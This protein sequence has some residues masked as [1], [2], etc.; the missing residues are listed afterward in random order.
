M[1][2]SLVA[3]LRNALTIMSPLLGDDAPEEALLM[4]SPWMLDA[5]RVDAGWSEIAEPRDEIESACKGKL[6]GIGVFAPE[7]GQPILGVLIVSRASFDPLGGVTRD[8]EDGWWFSYHLDGGT[9]AVVMHP[10]PI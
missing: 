2:A 4:T 3:T 6:D 5:L 7:S 8:G 9:G 1:S 10:E